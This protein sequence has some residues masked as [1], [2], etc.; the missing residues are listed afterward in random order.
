[1]TQEYDKRFQD[2]VDELM[3]LQRDAEKI[4]QEL[5][6]NYQYAH[7]KTQETADD[8]AKKMTSVERS[9]ANINIVSENITGYM[10]QCEK[11]ADRTRKVFMGMLVACVL[12]VAGTLWWSHYVRDDLAEA[13]KQ[14]ELLGP[15]LKNSPVLVSVNGHDYV[16]IVPGTE[17]DE[18][19]YYQDK[20]HEKIEGEYAQVWHVR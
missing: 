1:M 3:V 13:E 6:S 8:L 11:H 18:L 10:A 7:K 20:D 15:I 14:L 12:I 4:T 17:T 16:R 5:K 19:G 2:C 9:L